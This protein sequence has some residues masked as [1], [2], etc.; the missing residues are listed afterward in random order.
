MHEVLVYALTVSREVSRGEKMDLRGTDPESYITED[1]LV[2]EDKPNNPRSH[3]A[4][5]ELNYWLIL[6]ESR[7]GCPR[8]RTTLCPSDCLP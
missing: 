8:T 7:C 2:Y 1:T 6:G 5:Y 3:T 4:G